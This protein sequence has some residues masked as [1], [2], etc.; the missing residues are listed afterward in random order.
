MG[1]YD[2][3]TYEVKIILYHLSNVIVNDFKSIFRV[4]SSISIFLQLRWGSSFFIVP[5]RIFYYIY[6][7]I[8]YCYLTKIS[9]STYIYL[10]STFK[11]HN[12]FDSY[13]QSYFDLLKGEEFTIYVFRHYTHKMSLYICSRFKVMLKGECLKWIRGNEENLVRN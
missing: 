3:K 9:A 6:F 12:P 10:L 4:I 2:V 7:I 5:F 11:S 8:K 13:T 1:M